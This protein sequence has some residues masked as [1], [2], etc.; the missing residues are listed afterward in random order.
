MTREIIDGIVLYIL[1]TYIYISVDT[2][3]YSLLMNH[4]QDLKSGL[5]AL[6]RGDTTGAAVCFKQARQLAAL[7]DDPGAEYIASYRLMRVYYTLKKTKEACEEFENATRILNSFI[8]HDAV[9][10]CNAVHSAHENMRKWH[11]DIIAGY[12]RSA[13][14]KD[15]YINDDAAK[16]PC[17]KYTISELRHLRTILPSTST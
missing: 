5:D 11:S 14:E 3:M 17:I 16:I 4:R 12:R 2:G 1:R 10:H 7:A 8:N 13:T 15:S 9:R 6:Q